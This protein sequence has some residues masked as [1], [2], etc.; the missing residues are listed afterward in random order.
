MM[1]NKVK[2]TIAVVVIAISAAAFG[3]A[4]E[5]NTS[6]ATFGEMA[7][8]ADMFMD[9][10]DWNDMDFNGIFGFS[11]FGANI[12]AGRVDLGAAV[13]PGPIYL[14]L[15]YNG[16]VTG[17]N[18]VTDKF[19]NHRLQLTNPDP[20]AD[21]ITEMVRGYERRRSD[22][23]AEYGVL[24]GI[25]GLGFKLTFEDT[26]AVTE[27]TGSTATYHERWNGTLTPSLTVGGQFGPISKIGFYM[28][29]HYGIIATDMTVVPAPGAAA[30]DTAT[31][32]YNTLSAAYTAGSAT[33]NPLL[34]FA[35]TAGSYIQPSLY[36]RMGFGDL[37][38]E[39][40]LA[41]RLYSVS[42]NTH[43]GGPNSQSGVA[44]VHTTYSRN[45]NSSM[46]ERET[47][48][49]NRFYL[50]DTITPSYN[51]SG[52]N[53][54]GSFSYSATAALPLTIGFTTNRLNYSWETGEDGPASNSFQVN[55]FYKRNDFFM[56]V[57]PSIAAGVQF[58]PA[59]FFSAQGGIKI[60]LFT[61]N[62]K[63]ERTLDVDNPLYGSQQDIDR[64]NNAR[65]NGTYNLTISRD[66]STTTHNWTFPLLSFAA[67]FTFSFREM[68]A[69]DFVFIKEANPGIAETIYE[70]IGTGLGSGETSVVL[71][72]KF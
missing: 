41:V 24:V 46:Y 15:Y 1:H 34:L 51:I 53:E 61:W 38:L 30:A 56:G 29:I 21:D 14:G 20:Y 28:P 66:E 36:L 7:T 5:S 44:N 31:V 45:F 32:R 10:L 3:F 13:K 48:W 37:S 59:S 63:N 18:W 19:V 49:N 50:S 33:N 62:M 70:S 65:N 35:D 4:Q 40:D 39:N 42:A 64:W 68:A 23:E 54:T 22:P 67:G 11:R 52:S 27:V 43:G 60:D 2:K 16:Q 6:I 47:V 17:I 8:Q 58:R 69:L 55:D 72:F 26:L 57:E 71:T 12:P 9:V 25:G